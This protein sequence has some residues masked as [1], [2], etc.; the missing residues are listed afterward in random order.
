V[1]IARL[2]EVEG[3]LTGYFEPIVQGSRFPNPEF[4]IPLHRRP[5]DLVAA[6]DDDK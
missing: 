6:S 5:P 3:F 2:G 4:H 1:R